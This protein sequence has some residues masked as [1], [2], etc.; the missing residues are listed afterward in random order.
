MKYKWILF[1]ADETLFSFKSY[2]GLKNVLKK[3]GVDFTQQDYVEYQKINQPLWLA[4]QRNEITA[5]DIQQKRFVK[6]SQLSG[7]DPFELNR[8]LMDEMVNLSKPLESV[9][10]MLNTLYGKVKM[11][12]I[13][14][15]FSHIQKARLEKTNTSHFFDLLV[16]SEE[17]GVAKPNIEIFEYT[18]SKMGNNVKPSEVLMVG[19]TLTSDILGGINAGFD[20]CW[21]NANNQVNNTA[22]KPTYEIKLAVELVNLV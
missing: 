21:I 2:L 7:L 6:L 5:Q 18:L 15:G 11:G 13:T 20:T 1:D 19:D 4:Y 14:N 9:M 16:V 10:D 22:I 12:I 17:V 3:Y 8:Q